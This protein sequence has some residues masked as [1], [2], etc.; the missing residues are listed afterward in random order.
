MI[1][2]CSTAEPCHFTFVAGNVRKLL[3]YDPEEF[4]KDPVFWRSRVHPEDLPELQ[5]GLQLLLKTGEATQRFRFQHKA[6]TYKWFRN[7]VCLGSGNGAGGTEIRGCWI[8]ITEKHQA[9]DAL[10]AAQEH[11][12]Q[13]VRERTAELEEANR[14]LAE[15]RERYHHQILS[16]IEREHRRF[17]QD[18]HDDLG[19]QLAGIEFLSNV[20]R[21][22]LKQKPLA[23]KAEEIA[24]LIR[25]AIN[26]ARRLARGLA[27]VDLE[28]HGLMRALALLAEHTSELFRVRCSFNCESPVPVNDLTAATHLYRI[29]QEAVTNSVNH[30]KAANIDII[31]RMNGNQVVLQIVDNGKGLSR[32]PTSRR[33]MGLKIMRHRAE[34]V[35]GTLTVQGRKSGG[36]AMVLCKAPI[37][38]LDGQPAPRPKSR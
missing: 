23:Q 18:L 38:A 2:S 16:I 29:A 20:L 25:E 5:A 6:G 14:K 37:H 4:L 34:A 15:S 36:G 21:Q 12:E 1:Y 27:P 33:G 28:S 32:P 26:H 31:L 7:D 35:G 10:K 11:L 22:Q 9:E 3:G 24:R 30:G 8:D 13:R 19:Q 17:A